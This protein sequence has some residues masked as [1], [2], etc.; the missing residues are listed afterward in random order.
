MVHPIA[1]ILCTA[2]MIV[3]ALVTPSI[4][5]LACGLCTIVLLALAVG[6]CFRVVRF[7][8]IAI[9]PMALLLF[10]VWGWL[11]AAPPGKPLGSDPVGGSVFAAVTALRLALMGSCLLTALL[12]IPPD[13]LHFVLRSC[14]IRASHLVVLLG[15]FASVPDLRRRAAQIMTARYARGL[16]GN[17]SLVSRVRQVPGILQ[18]L[19][20]SVLRTAIQRAHH[21][22]ERD[23]LGQL[24]RLHPNVSC[25]SFWPTIGVASVTTAWV[26][27]AIASRL[28]VWQ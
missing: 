19:L 12:T 11:V 16:F 24:E 26:G 23:I 22:E 7:L 14:G 1:R 3:G 5:V 18:S 25:S 21:W 28:R 27:L 15:I 6:V 13:G 10:L 8:A 20:G 17:R 2:V 4:V 9:G